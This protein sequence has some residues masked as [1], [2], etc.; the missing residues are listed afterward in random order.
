[1]ISVEEYKRRFFVAKNF[2][3]WNAEV[4]ARK[5]EPVH[6]IWEGFIPYPGVTLLTGASMVGKTTLLAMLLDRRRQGGALLGKTVQPGT[7]LVLTEEDFSLWGWRQQKL[8]FGPNVCFDNLAT[9][10][11]DDL[12]EYIDWILRLFL[13]RPF[14]L[15]VIDSLARF[16]P[17]GEN[18]PASL[19]K[20]MDEINMISDRTIGVLLQHHPRRAGG[21]PGQAARGSGALPALVD[22]LLDM[23]LPPGDPFTRRRH[24]FGL[25]RYPEIP[26]YLL[27]E[28]NAEA[29]DYAV[30]A[31]AALDAVA[32]APILD[33]LRVLLG[34]AGCPLTR[35]GILE[36]WPHAA[37]C[38]SPSTLWR[39]LMRACEL[40]VLVRDGDGMKGAA[41]RFTLA[42]VPTRLAPA[43][44]ELPNPEET[45]APEELPRPAAI[46]IAAEFA[47]NAADTTSSP[48]EPEAEPIETAPPPESFAGEDVLPSIPSV[49]QRH[50]E[51]P[52]E[53]TGETLADPAEL[54]KQPPSPPPL[55]D[56]PQHAS[57][58]LH[59]MTPI[60]ER[61]DAG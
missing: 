44:D 3:R 52:N 33:Q 53:P 13:E 48:S 8:D 19:R 28:M 36:R 6:W 43:N 4:A 26:Q 15:L 56:L 27:I 57:W 55:P 59:L 17:V 61:S 2:G 1:M 58:L 24:L 31:D 12:E 50:D 29:T 5:Q 38:P 22:V 46:S 20:L 9:R 60:P 42:P 7:T 10:S 45:P 30:L 16:L 18:H 25:G 14:E 39:W 51:P 34:Q 32:F 41:Y 49:E 54:A 47:D 35:Q 11:F 23:R 21:R 40:G 37:T